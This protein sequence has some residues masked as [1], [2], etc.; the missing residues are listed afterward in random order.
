MNALHNFTH[1][2]NLILL[3]PISKIPMLITQ[4]P[5][6]T[7]IKYAPEYY[8]KTM[9]YQWMFEKLID[10]YALLLCHHYAIIML[11]LCHYYA[12]IML[13]S[14]H[15]H[16]YPCIIHCYYCIVNN[17]HCHTTAFHTTHPF[18]TITSLRKFLSLSHATPF[19]HFMIRHSK[20][21]G[22]VRTAAAAAQR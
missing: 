5:Q 17:F 16:M 15:C 20:A 10:N 7:L 9:L 2:N 1:L 21:T 13:L 3:P 12:I 8:C 22:S 6:L 11:L 19:C 4:K 14:C 18:S